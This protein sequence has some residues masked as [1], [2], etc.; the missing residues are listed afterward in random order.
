ML[1]PR[2][3][4][5]S[6]QLVQIIYQTQRSLTAREQYQCSPLLLSNAAIRDQHF[7]ANAQP[8][9]ENAFSF[10]SRLFERGSSLSNCLEFHEI[11]KRSKRAQ[12]VWGSPQVRR[13]FPAERRERFAKKKRTERFKDRCKWLQAIGIKIRCSAGR[14]G[15]RRREMVLSL[16]FIRCAAEISALQLTRGISG[17]KI[18][19]RLSTS[20]RVHARCIVECARIRCQGIFHPSR[21]CTPEVYFPGR[22]ER[23]SY[24]W[25]LLPRTGKIGIVFRFSFFFFLSSGKTTR[26]LHLLSF[27]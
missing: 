7:S 13:R 5:L 8:T 21:M 19:Q 24:V 27:A 15:E 20:A 3:L 22:E 14:W 17:R 4:N 18:F 1:H 11:K 25:F 6:S 12:L 26:F 16:V 9:F 10:S 23:N 2:V